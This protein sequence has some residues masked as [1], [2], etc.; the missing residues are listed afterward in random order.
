MWG[1]VLGYLAVGPNER[2]TRKIFT[3]P[4]LSLETASSRALAGVLE[5]PERRPSCRAD[6]RYGAH[7][8]PNADMAQCL[9]WAIR[10]HMQCSNRSRAI[11]V[12]SA[13]FSPAIGAGCKA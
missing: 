11:E 3:V 6:V 10:R 9:S 13:E 5:R 12:C 8:G 7:F 2:L 1:P 4:P